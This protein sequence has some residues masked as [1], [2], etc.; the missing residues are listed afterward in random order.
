[1]WEWQLLAE[2]FRRKVMWRW[3]WGRGAGGG[4]RGRCTMWMYTVHMNVWCL[5]NDPTENRTGIVCVVIWGA[6][7]HR[8]F[9]FPPV[10]P[11]VS[12]RD[13]NLVCLVTSKEPRIIDFIAMLQHCPPTR[14]GIVETG[15]DRACAQMRH[16]HAHTHTHTNKRTPNYKHRFATFKLQWRMMIHEKAQNYGQKDNTK[17]F[18]PKRGIHHM[19]RFTCTTNHHQKQMLISWE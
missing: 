10:T 11:F 6:S 13:D 7:L 17:I 18:S 16:T 8:A 15:S 1:M 19:M 4:F 14:R 12:E 5:P 9:S 3:K 2:G